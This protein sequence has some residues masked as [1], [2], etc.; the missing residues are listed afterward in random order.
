MVVEQIHCFCTDHTLCINEWDENMAGLTGKRSPAVIGKKYHKVLPMILAGGADA[1]GVGIKEGK[2]RVLKDYAF[3]C[4]GG[5]TKADITISPLKNGNGKVVGAK[6]CISPTSTCSAFS[7]LQDSQRLIDIGK[8]A[9][10]L[11]HGVRNP[12]NAIKGAVVYLGEKY[13]DEPTL[14]EFTN[15][16]GSEISRLDNFIS[17]FLSASLS[18]AVPSRVDVNSL[19]EKVEVFTSLQMRAGSVQPLFEYGDVPKV[20]INTF[21]LEQAVLNVINN[22]LEA[23]PGGGRLSVRSRSEDRFGSRVAVIEISDTGRGMSD[24]D[25]TPLPKDNGRGFG[26]FITREILQYYGGRLEIETSRGIGATV[27]LCLPV[28]NAEE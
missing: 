22:S 5:Q 4:L 9:S 25:I 12:L 26:L 8:M 10:T 7:K 24:A 13:S 6:V 16:M 14:V 20:A 1:V 17:R 2:P 3:N 19:L 27:R 18:D 11:A 28:N 21:Q 15:L 23:M